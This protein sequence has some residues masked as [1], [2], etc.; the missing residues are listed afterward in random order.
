MTA[1]VVIIR[2]LGRQDYLAMWD[3]MQQFT[4]QRI[5]DETNATTDEIWLLEHHPVFTQGQNG[6]PEHILNPGDIPI[7]QTDRGGQVTYHGPG[8]L[9]VYV[10]IDLKRKKFNVRQFVTLLEQS[11]IDMLAAHGILAS[12]K[13]DAP[14]VYVA[15]KKLCSIGLR[16]RRGC[17]Y[18]GIAFN[19]NMDLTPFLRINPCGFTGLK[20]TQLA[21][22]NGPKNV[23]DASTQ[24]ANFLIKNLGYTTAH[25]KTDGKI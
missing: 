12:A 11:V 16:I 5:T 15:G 3:A 24:L 19:V 17:S 23:S 21:E 18:H 10:L 13:C 2:S 6:K 25:F 7:V 14:G 4:N 9:M 8:Q 1:D 20:M 22:L